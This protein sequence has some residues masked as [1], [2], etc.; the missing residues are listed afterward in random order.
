ML[1]INTFFYLLF[2]FDI[3]FIMIIPIAAKII[4]SIHL[5]HFF[6]V[7]YNQKVKQTD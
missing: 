6:L 4:L 3:R 5:F 1:P 7:E 2:E